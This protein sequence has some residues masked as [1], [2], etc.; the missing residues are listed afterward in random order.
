MNKESEELEIMKQNYYGFNLSETRVHEIVEHALKRNE[1][2]KLLKE[3]K[4]LNDEWYMLFGKCP[5]CNHYNLF[6]SN[7]CSNCG[8]ALEKIEKEE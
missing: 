3:K 6:T 5:V 2:V 7:Y 8:Q 4:Y 1:P